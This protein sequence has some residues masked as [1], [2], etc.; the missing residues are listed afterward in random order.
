MWRY[1]TLLPLCMSLWHNMPFRMRYSKNKIPVKGAE[2]MCIHGKVF[3]LFTKEP[4]T[5]LMRSIE[6]DFSVSTCFGTGFVFASIFVVLT[7]PRT[8]RSTTVTD[9]SRFQGFTRT[10]IARRLS[11]DVID[12]VLL[13][14]T[15]RSLAIYERFVMNAFCDEFTGR[16]SYPSLHMAIWSCLISKSKKQNLLVDPSTS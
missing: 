14:T 4:R 6:L 10:H 11:Y 7:T 16:G 3:V 9:S 2:V 13:L 5:E 15:R 1:I 12:Q 8:S